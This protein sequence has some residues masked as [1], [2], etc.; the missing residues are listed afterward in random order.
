MPF[1]SIHECRYFDK[2]RGSVLFLQ[3][4]SEDFC[5]TTTQT[6]E[7]TEPIVSDEHRVLLGNSS[8]LFLEEF[9]RTLLPTNP[10]YFRSALVYQ[11]PQRVSLDRFRLFPQLLFCQWRRCTLHF[12]DGFS[13]V[14][15]ILD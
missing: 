2:W 9:V 6:R 3:Y 15:P 8:R 10:C 5:L 4:S 12:T 13:I 1:N 11:G 14:E 7:E